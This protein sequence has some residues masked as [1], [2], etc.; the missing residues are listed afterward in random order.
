MFSKQHENNIE[1]AA[2]AKTDVKETAILS[3]TGY[4]YIQCCTYTQPQRG[5]RVAVPHR[6]ESEFSTVTVGWVDSAHFE[7]TACPPNH[8]HY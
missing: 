8:T 7:W 6:S 5:C 4:L 3:E 1:K 2:L